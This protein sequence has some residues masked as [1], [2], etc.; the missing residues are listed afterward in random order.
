[1]AEKSETAASGDAS[2][3]KPVVPTVNW[4]DSNM[5]TSY[6]NVVNAASTREEVT[7]FFGTNQTWKVANKQQEFNVVLSDR[8]ILNPLAARRLWTILGA[9]LK[10]YETRFGALN[11][12]RG[13]DVG[14]AS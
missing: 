12:D 2:S 11:L 3:G 13:R 9:V 7:L 14:G 6:A 4:D 5:K 1:M 8:I 10:E